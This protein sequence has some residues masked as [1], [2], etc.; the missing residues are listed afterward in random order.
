MCLRPKI[1]LFLFVICESGDAATDA[2]NEERQFRML[3]G[4]C[5]KL[6][7]IRLYRFYATLH[8]WNGIALTLQPHALAHDGPKLAVGV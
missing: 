6:I 8:C 3:L 1:F 4:E 5:N 2:G 7:H